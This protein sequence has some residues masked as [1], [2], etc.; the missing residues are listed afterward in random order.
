M[1][2]RRGVW[3]AA[4]AA[5][6]VA[7]LAVGWLYGALSA[8]NPG[9]RVVAHDAAT[10]P[11]GPGGAL[12]SLRSQLEAERQ[13][14]E[15]LAR[16]LA[17]L[18]ERVDALGRAGSPDPARRADGTPS[19]D[20]AV[21][22]RADDPRK[23]SERPEEA[24]PAQAARPSPTFDTEALVA[25]GVDPRE[26][27]VLHDRWQ[28]H[29]MDKLYLNDQAMREGWLMTPRHRD[30]HLAL[31]AAFRKEIG[32][33]GYDAYLFATGS[34]N[35]VVVRDV[36]SAS[37]ADRLGLEVGDEIRRYD[38]SPVHTPQDLS[39][40]TSSGKAG[41]LVPIEIV[42]GGRSIRLR[43]ERGPIGVA[44]EGARRPPDAR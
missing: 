36:F 39:L 22:R 38:G 4:A 23:A 3:V 1:S 44:I 42:R 32:E 18:R 26:V 28:R 20:P 17:A 19:A 2:S 40:A 10:P 7:G 5:L 6:A 15:A 27:T 43:I 41:E 16:D 21:A 24:N 34:D 29:Q 37:V 30:Q 9:E 31:D 33:D 13:A 12:D 8:P 11:P 25:A 35:R 14:R